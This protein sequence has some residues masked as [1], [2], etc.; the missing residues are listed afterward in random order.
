[1]DPFAPHVLLMLIEHANPNA[2]SIHDLLTC[3][4]P[5][6]QEAW[7]ETPNPRLGMGIPGAMIMSPGNHDQIYHELVEALR[8]D[9]QS[10]KR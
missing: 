1:M 10:L 4:P 8:E 2:R 6:A 9:Y 3:L 7:L 5:E